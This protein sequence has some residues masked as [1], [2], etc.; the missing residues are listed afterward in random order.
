MLPLW[1]K[2]TSASRK[3]Y[4]LMSIATDNMLTSDG[5]LAAT[6]TDTYDK[7]ICLL[8]YTDK[9]CGPLHDGEGANFREPEE[10]F[11]VYLAFA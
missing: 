4:Q 9:S 2:A 1:Q 8:R 3:V 6:G 10:L 7:L 11:F 5:K